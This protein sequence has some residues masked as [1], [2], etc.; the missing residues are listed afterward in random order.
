MN[1]TCSCAEGYEGRNCSEGI[2][3]DLHLRMLSLFKHRISLNGPKRKFDNYVSFV[4]FFVD[5]DYSMHKLNKKLKI[6]FFFVVSA[7]DECRS[8][9]CQNGATCNDLH[10]N[11]T[12]SCTV[13]YSG[14]HCETGRNIFGAFCFKSRLKDLSL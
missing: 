7:I 8:D 4:V 14:R 12:C 3:K 5:V 2:N 10:N 11:Y 13:E 1:Y 9:P 6:V